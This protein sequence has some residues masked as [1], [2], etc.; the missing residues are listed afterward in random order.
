MENAIDSNNLGLPKLPPAILPGK[1]EFEGSFFH[2][3]I[4]LK[5]DWESRQQEL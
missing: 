3:R 2:L 4:E 5:F 1:I